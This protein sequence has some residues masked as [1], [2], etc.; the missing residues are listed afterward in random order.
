MGVS[1]VHRANCPSSEL[2]THQQIFIR[3]WILAGTYNG[4]QG[5]AEF[6]ALSG[7][8][9]GT[10][11]MDSGGGHFDEVRLNAASRMNSIS[12]SST[13]NRGTTF[14]CPI[15]LVQNCFGTELMTPTFTTGETSKLSSLTLAFLEDLGYTVDNTQADQYSIPSGASCLCNRRGLRNSAA[16]AKGDNRYRPKPS[17]AA[18]RNVILQ[19][20]RD[21]E[22]LYASGNGSPFISM[23]FTEESEDGSFNLFHVDVELDSNPDA[24]WENLGGRH[25]SQSV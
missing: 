5:N 1:I 9:S 21:L 11:P 22:E 15:D 25:L 16:D 18:V 13:H 20:L 23:Y 4:A 2:C 19:G 3:C 24:A 17:Q 10:I 6:Q 12:S 14:A 8:A 7:C